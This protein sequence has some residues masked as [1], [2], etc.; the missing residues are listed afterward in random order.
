MAGRKQDE[1]RSGQQESEGQ[2]R[3]MFELVGI[4]EAQVDPVT[5]RFLR[6]NPKMCEIT[7]YS[8]EELLGM[9]FY[10]LTHP[11]DRQESGQG[12]ERVARGEKPGYSAEERFVRKDTRVVWVSM[13]VRPVRDETGR[14]LRLVADVQDLTE[15]KKIEEELKSS[16]DQLEVILSG[17]ADGI[18]A[19]DST[20]RLIYANETAARIVGYPSALALLEASVREVMQ[21]FEVID[22]SGQP[23]PLERLP[24]RVALQGDPAPEALLRFRT[25]ATGEERWSLVKARPVYDN[26]GQVRSAVNIFHDITERKQAEET[27]ARL[28]ALVESSEDAIIGKTLDGTITTW[29]KGAEKIYGYSTREAIGRSISMLVPPD[30]PDE[31]PQ[32]LSSV[33]RGEAIKHYETIR[34]SKDG[35]YLNISL[36]VSPIRDPLGNV[37]GASTIARD[38]TERKWVQEQMRAVREAERGR[39][40]RELHDE[41]LQDL[42]FALAEAQSLQII[43]KDTE[44]D[45]RLEGVVEALKR[46]GQG[47]RGAIYDLRL[48]ENRERT[49]VEMFESLIELNRRLSPERE[50]LFEVEKGFPSNP[51]RDEDSTELVRILQEALA[52]ARRHSEARHIRVSVGTSG[53]RLWTEVEDDG[54]GFNPTEASTIGGFGIKGMYER[55]RVLGGDLKIESEPGKGT[56]VRFDVAL[57]IDGEEPKSE[58]EVRVLLVEDHASFREAAAS[59][60][61]R[62]PE[63]T[64]AGQA[65]SLAEARGLLYGIDM[66]IIDLG[67]PDGYGGEL[68]KELRDANPQAQALVLSASLERAQIARAVE[69]GAAGV[70]HKSTGIEE[71]VDA[72]R[73]LRAGET[74]LSLEEVVELLRYAGSHR[75]QYQEA[76]K[77]I[78]SL[79]QR[80]KEVLQALAEGLDNKGIAERLHI[81]LETSRNHMAS[82]LT[83]LGVHSRLQALVFA[84]RNGVV[85]IN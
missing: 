57:L 8:E 23:V 83:K 71:V 32:I 21:K 72:V 27:Q 70:L 9:T 73:R 47:L 18:T 77:A 12:L 54:Q 10:E 59:I 11:D 7:A 76:Q 51:L 22:E 63:F 16:R 53:G 49:L 66:A 81:S 25:V 41:A 29:N 48:E 80:E 39:L 52:N 30:L 50:I 84:L 69:A 31:I 40:A 19:Q 64:I 24:G 20:G 6:V 44:L 3:A 28:A 85:D 61:E 82:I 79:T 43:S 58:E 14:P 15:R 5:G 36:S 60:L 65:G 2:Y 78:A 67:L 55:A 45:R 1:D 13:N 37:V 74:L 75:E 35:R 46:A 62:E 68:I 4:G 33:R 42:T 17:V 26:E 34:V 38:V 56:K